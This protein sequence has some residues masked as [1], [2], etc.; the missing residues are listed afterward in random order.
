MS[1]Y[2]ICAAG[3]YGSRCRVSPA[4]GSVSRRSRRRSK[5]RPR[6]T[7]I[8]TASGSRSRPISRCRREGCISAGP[9]RRSPRKRGITA[10]KCGPSPL[11]ERQ[12]SRP[13]RAGL[14]VGAAWHHDDRQGLSRRP[15]GVRGSR[16][17][18]CRGARPRPANLQGRPE[19]TARARGALR[20]AAGRTSSSWKRSAA[21]S[22]IADLKRI[23]KLDRFGLRGPMAHATGHLRRHRTDPEENDEADSSEGGPL[24]RMGRPDASEACRDRRRCCVFMR[25]TLDV[26]AILK[27]SEARSLSPV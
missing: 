24:G 15:A 4:A 20:F 8:T 16:N 17:F 12:S 7:S 11:R 13:H 1:G 14:D 27:V 25:S 19:L 3:G 22:R 18:R 21:S 26:D 9:I 23:Q 10:P 2:G 6:S 5:T